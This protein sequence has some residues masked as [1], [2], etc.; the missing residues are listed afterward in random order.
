MQRVGKFNMISDCLIIAKIVVIACQLMKINQ[1][2]RVF[3][4][5]TKISTVSEIPAVRTFSQCCQY[6]L[7]LSRCGPGCL[8]AGEIRDFCGLS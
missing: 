2:G 5:K 7:S 1:I 8:D 3:C 4:L 6:A